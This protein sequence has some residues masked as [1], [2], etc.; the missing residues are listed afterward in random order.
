MSEEK[1][2]AIIVG[3]GL[4]GCSAAIVLANA[5][6]EVL[7]VERGDFCGAK[8]MTGGRLYG[9]S[10][11]KIIPNFAEEAPVER[12]ITKEKVS[13]MSPEGSL[14]IGF[15]SKK[16]SS[17]ADNASYTVLRATFD[18]WLASKAEEAGVEII[19]GILVDNLILE[20]GK[21]VGV[22]ATGEELYAD[23]VVIADGVNSL[24]AQ[25]IGMKKELE[26][27][28]VAVGAKEVI[29]LG[30]EVINQRF[31]IGSEEGVAWLSCGD[32]TMGGFGGGLVYTNKDTVSVGIVATLSDIG[33]TDLSINQLLD[34]FKEHPSIAPYIEGGETIEYSGHLVPEEGIHMIPELYRDGVL[35][36]GDAAG[37][38]INLGF[39]VR[40]MDFAVESGR[41]AAET[42]IKAHGLGDFS[43]EILSD[44]A[45]RLENSFIMKDMKTYKGFPTLLGRREIF[46][47][48][49]EM[50]TDIAAKAFTVD[51]KP[52][53]GLIMYI[54]NSF[55]EHTSA[56]EFVNLISTVL[57]AF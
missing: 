3:G 27:H 26:P 13:L 56:S 35:V 44:Y 10:L 41:L 39:T 9:H 28:Q 11:E 37:F 6:L 1:F 12:K 52:G 23:V 30:E 51:G 42:I 22:E 16:L 31:G 17:E 47:N 32:P 48:L 24:L 57:E 45:K 43:A 21:V 14:D 2:D 54:I 4:A 38:C 8:N 40:G 33:H 46:E 7:L 20:D 50:A 19:P 36:V 34:R 5:G 15:R 29:R 55:A 25:K 53:Q 18:Q 49:P